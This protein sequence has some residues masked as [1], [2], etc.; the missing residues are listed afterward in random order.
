MRPLISKSRINIWGLFCI[1]LIAV[2]FTVILAVYAQIMRKEQVR[3]QEGAAADTAR[4]FLYF[5]SDFTH[6]QNSGNTIFNSL[7]YRHLRNPAG[8]YQEE[9]HMIRRSEI[10]QQLHAKVL[11]MKF[12]S[13]ILV[14]TPDYVITKDGWFRHEQYAAYYHDVQITGQG[15]EIE[16]VAN[17]ESVFPFILRDPYTILNQG[18]VCLLIDRMDFSEMIS[19]ILP[20]EM[21][22]SRV[23]LQGRILYEKGEKGTELF[24]VRQEMQSPE[25]KLEIGVPGY[26][27]R[28][29]KQNL[30]TLALC[31]MADLFACIV[32]AMFFSH[33]IAKPL[34]KLI[35]QIGGNLLDD[36]YSQLGSFITESSQRNEQLR[37]RENQ[38]STSIEKIVAYTQKE[39]LLNMLTNRDFDFQEE[40]VGLYIPWIGEGYFF[41]FML[42]EN[43]EGDAG[44]YMEKQ[45]ARAKESLY[46]P[47]WQEQSC[48]FLW[49]EKIEL[50][51]NV[52]DELEKE[53]KQ[54]QGGSFRC[55]CSDILFEP[56]TIYDNYCTIEEEFERLRES[57]HD[58]PLTLQVKLVQCFYNGNISKFLEIA[59][60]N[61]ELY[62]AK[63]F[64]V[65]LTKL[66]GEIT[67]RPPGNTALE[68]ETWE[69][70]QEQVQKLQ[71]EN[72]AAQEKDRDISGQLI[73]EYIGEHFCEEDMCVKKLADIFSIHR[74]LISKMVKSYT[75]KSFSDYLLELRIQQAVKLM[76]TTE[77]SITMIS[78][79]IGYTNYITFKRAFLRAKG[80][81]P[82]E[83]RE[84]RF[85]RES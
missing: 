77:L 14:I 24:A 61:W 15:S 36:P 43:P 62:G 82:R 1:V 48:L 2:S 80:L 33:I 66:I 12:V 19:R 81:S 52:Q 40:L 7:W 8:I 74:T 47:L 9:F 34:A 25:T 73:C 39:M 79:K 50:A 67:R 38:L 5:S 18:V 72:R 70:F 60:K 11:S 55:V 26:L 65:F 16:I 85:L 45:I 58:L 28:Y 53:M 42:M 69:A 27:P 21:T 83:Y 71:Q 44:R 46:F 54:L 51:Q 31:F 30:L 64:F 23:T 22:Y 4:V 29:W 68:H 59:Q 17:K 35:R 37:Q 20:E 78:E 3:Y 56:E 57:P 49:F 32:I 41:F 13:N 63:A 75:Q 10:S 6:M 76:E 84:N